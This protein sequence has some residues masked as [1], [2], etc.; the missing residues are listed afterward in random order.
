MCFFDLC[1]DDEAGFITEEKLGK[2]FRK[3]L[4]SEVE[5]REVKFAVK[6]MMKEINPK[7]KT[8]I[9]KDELYEAAMQNE[10]LKIVIEKNVKLLKYQKEKVKMNTVNFLANQNSL[11]SGGIFFPYTKVMMRA[12]EDREKI[13]ER[14]EKIRQDLNNLK[15]K[16]HSLGESDSD[17]SDNYY[18]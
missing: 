7:G 8:H 17:I 11:N 10:N 1:D 3:N 16:D 15:L 5:R 12:F 13:Y 2:F 9:L 4:R 18:D 6:D 14:K